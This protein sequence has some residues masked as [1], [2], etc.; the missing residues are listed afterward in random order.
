[1]NEPNEQDDEKST[2]L[3]PSSIFIHSGLHLVS[4]KVSKMKLCYSTQ[5][6]STAKRWAPG[7]VNFVAAVAYHFC[8]ALLVAFMQPCA[9]LLADALYLTDTMTMIQT[10]GED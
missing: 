9:R 3:V 7:F 10:G 2:K 6:Q 8:L 1:M 5:Q 4:R